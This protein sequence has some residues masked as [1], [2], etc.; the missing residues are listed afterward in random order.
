MEFAA[1]RALLATDP[2]SLIVTTGG[3]GFTPRDITPEATL[4]VIER[5]AP[6][7]EDL[8]RRAG[9]AKGLVTAVLSRAVSGITG[10]TWIVNL[11]GSPGGVRDGLA[12][13]KPILGH[14]LDQIEG[15]SSH[16]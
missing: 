11:P 6:G 4:E 7:I 14:A 16:D 5:R 2:P 15:E 9:E 3:T 10:R 13:I 12:A 8:L 1:L